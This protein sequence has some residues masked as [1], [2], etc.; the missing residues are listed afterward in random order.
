MNPLAFGVAALCVALGLGGCARTPQAVTRPSEMY[1]LQTKKP[2]D[3]YAVAYDARGRGA[4]LVKAST[5][6][7]TG[8]DGKPGTVK[9]SGLV[10]CAEPPPD[11]AANV[12]ANREVNAAVEA[13]VKLKAVEVAAKGSGG[14]K[15]SASS[16]IASV[17]TRTELVLLM[18]DAL[19]RICEMNANGVLSNEQAEA[20]FRQV[21]START[22][23]QRDNVGKLIDVLTV[24]AQNPSAGKDNPRLVDELVSTIRLLALGDQLVQSDQ[25]A[26]GIAAAFAS[27]ILVAELAKIDDGKALEKIS[28][29]IVPMLT[30]LK[31]RRGNLRAGPEAAELDKKIKL[32]EEIAGSLNLE[33]PK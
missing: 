13:L 22:L 11:V 24:I 29:L 28:A 10:F 32:L 18:R 27:Q 15:D 9:R 6:S 3:G 19:Y 21:L 4:Y 20:V 25:G 7:T 17:A 30:S 14:T 5:E 12:S 8:A 23:G 2:G 1:P 26:S 33:L 16:E 31:S